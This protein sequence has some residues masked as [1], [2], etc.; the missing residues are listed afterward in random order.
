MVDKL[1][2]DA[3]QPSNTVRTT[4]FTVQ[5]VQFNSPL[6]DSVIALHATKSARLGLFPEGAFREYASRRLVLGAVAANANLSGYLL[7]RVAKN[8]AGIVHLAIDG[9]F[10]RRG[11][12]RVL[13]DQ[14][15]IETKHL[16]GISL[17]C[18]RDYGLDSLWE[19]FGFTV[20]HSKAGRGA[21]G[22]LLDYWWFDH[23][24]HDLFSLAAARDEAET[25]VPVAI[26]ANVFYDLIGDPRPQGIDT[27]VLQAD[28]L[29]EIISLRITPELYNEIHRA[30]DEG[31]KKRARV[32]AQNWQ[33]LKTDDSRVAV[34]E[35]DLRLMFNK[36]SVHRDESDVRQIAH[37][38][39]ADIPF[40][41]TR[42]QPVL[43]HSDQVFETYG[44]RIIH[45]VDLIA[46]F[47][48]LHRAAEY[49][50]ASLEGSR[51]RARLV[52]AEDIPFLSKAFKHKRD[53][54]TSEFQ[55]VVRHYLAHNTAWISRVIVDETDKPS[56]YFVVSRSM[57]DRV[58]IRVLRHLDHALSGTL[59][60]HVVHELNRRPEDSRRQLICVTEKQISNETK[61]A[62]EEL[63]FVPNG[64]FWWKLAL[65]GIVTP[66]QLGGE[67]E[68]SSLPDEM[69]NGLGTR[70]LSSITTFDSQVI[71]RL[72][73]LFSP[74]K[75]V[76]PQTPCFV[77]S[78]R[79]S[80][81]AHFFDI[82]VGSQML[83]D[84]NERL[85]LG[86]EGAY[87]CSANNRHLTAPGRLLWY[88]SGGDSMMIKA[89]SHLEEIM[90]GTPKELYGKLRHLGVYSWKHVFET[91]GGDLNRPLMAFRFS[92]TERFVRPVSREEM[93]QTGIP[94]PQNPRRITDEQFAAIYRAGMEPT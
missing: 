90:L 68:N 11:V 21:D 59:V 23:N 64:E 38:I 84:L 54:R 94:Q 7:Y 40:F 4:G 71:A 18:R 15:K 92:R 35:T 78:I 32:A 79:P 19:H 22:A 91:A 8:R 53:E 2:Q 66:K 9:A 58:E 6:L 13:M 14:L 37:A 50:P 39:A 55:T 56:V 34:I 25:V 88:V 52:T 45:P 47:D 65:A 72:E 82:P 44:I 36:G 46:R 83:M 12:A 87:Y 24:H 1:N 27:R 62:L 16:L 69:K 73:Q 49:R 42:D 30:K 29:Q 10:T 74:V 75:I 3:N 31:E 63:G 89:C 26:D 20:R 80:W 81:A 76:S 60:R 51:W 48:A 57:P 86:I 5:H 33:E 77:V 17:K 41:A 85:H 67:I 93:L 70:L 61:T 28:W 43:D